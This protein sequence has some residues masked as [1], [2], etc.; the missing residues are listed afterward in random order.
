MTSVAYRTW[1]GAITLLGFGIRLATVLGRPDRK[2]GGDAFY[3]HAAANLL[4]KGHGFIDPWLYGRHPP[5]VVQMAD[6]PPL[7]VFVLAA[8]VGGRAQDL[9]R[10]PGVVLCHRCGRGDRVRYDR[11]GRSRDAEPA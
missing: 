8:A 4:V 11:A 10:P 2:P 6:W 7:F 5:Q 9:L 3:F 1:L